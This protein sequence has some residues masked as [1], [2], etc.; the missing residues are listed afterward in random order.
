ML[1]AIQKASWLFYAFTGSATVVLRRKQPNLPRPFLM[2]L[3]PL[4]PIVVVC[5]SVCLVAASLAQDP[6]FC[7]IAL[8]FV[9]AGFPVYDLTIGRRRRR[10]ATTPDGTPAATA[11]EAALS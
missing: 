9:A 3:Y 10:R 7:A 6:L 8:A 11:A 2:P 5:L 1:S 4:P